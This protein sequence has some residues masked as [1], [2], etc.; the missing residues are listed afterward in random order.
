[1]QKNA[2]IVVCLCVW[3]VLSATVFGQVSL[4]DKPGFKGATTNTGQAIQYPTTT[5]PEIIGRL[6]VFSARR[7]YGVAS[8]SGPHLHPRGRGHPH[9]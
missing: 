8:T 4:S 2:A 1:M 5:T 6:M 3:L 7:G 9:H